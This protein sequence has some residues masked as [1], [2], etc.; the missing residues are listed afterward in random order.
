MRLSPL[1]ILEILGVVTGLAYTLLITYGY[2]LCWVFALSS[3]LI[4]LY[5]CFRKKIYAE[6][7]LQAFYIY[8]AIYGWM[9]WS[10]S[11]GAIGS[12]LSWNVHGMIILAGISLVLIS[13]F[14]LRRMTDAATPF[15]DSFTTVF[16]IF[17]TVLMINLIPDNWWYWIVIDAVSVYLYINRKLYLTAGL[18]GLYTILA[19]NGLLEWTM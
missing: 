19:V 18:F 5:I 15:V 3:S 2:V 10:E 17:A 6:S 8:T 7:L 4:Y 1:R 16:S 11:E 12:S 14:L 13:G 9:H